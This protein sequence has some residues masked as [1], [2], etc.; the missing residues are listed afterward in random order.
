[1]CL[2]SLVIFFPFSFLQ[3]TSPHKNTRHDTHNVQSTFDRLF[4]V[5]KSV[6]SRDSRAK[7]V[8]REQ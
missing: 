6:C 4:S 2:V 5:S 7:S 3:L 8:Q 1:M